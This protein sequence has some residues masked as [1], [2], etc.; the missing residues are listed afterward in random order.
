MH[1]LLALVPVVLAA[2]DTGPLPV[3]LGIDVVPYEPI[4]VAIDPGLGDG[5]L[6]AKFQVSLA[7]R[8]FNPKGGEDRNDGLWLA[9]SQTSLWDLQSES[10]PFYDSSYRPEAWWHVGLPDHGAASKLGIEPGIGHESNGKGGAD[11]RS[12]NHV[13][14]R[15]VGQFTSGDATFFATPRGRIYI[16]DEDNPD[17]ADYRGYVD[18]SGGM[19]LAGGLGLSATGRIGSGADHGSL[20]L[21][22]T[23][24]LGPWTGGRM[25]GF[26]YA[27]WFAGYSES[28]LGYD[29]R[30][31][32]P[33]V[34]FGYALTR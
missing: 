21:E 23:H 25:S 4:Y 28:L 13:F 22:A 2:A 26:L 5:P 9:Y 24:P 15:C 14:V 3:E 8:L 6:S 29:Q 12:I 27:Q 1:V 34:L 10:K 7:I 17:I 31:E 32:Q 33:R 19:R 30:S 20:L 11:S 16:E 18:L